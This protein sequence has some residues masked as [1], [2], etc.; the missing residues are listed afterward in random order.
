MPL[1][2]AWPRLARLGTSRAGSLN[3]SAGRF[4]PGPARAA[5]RPADPARLCRWLWHLFAYEPP[6]L[7]AGWER[8]RRVRWPLSGGAGLLRGDESSAP[9]V[10]LT[11]AERTVLRQSTGRLRASDWRPTCRGAVKHLRKLVPA[12]GVAPSWLNHSRALRSWG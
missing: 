7:F 3:A 10:Q 11:E 1:H 5:G 6:L 4:V 8:P 9:P 12:R 2:E